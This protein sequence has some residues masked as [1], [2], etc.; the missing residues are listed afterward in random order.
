MTSLILVQNT[1][2]GQRGIQY[3]PLINILDINVSCKSRWSRNALLVLKYAYINGSK[4][5]QFGFFIAVFIAVSKRRNLVPDNGYCLNLWSLVT[6]ADFS[7][8][9]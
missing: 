2:A 9:S 1:K 7:R 6:M 5:S 4:S 8:Q 3:L